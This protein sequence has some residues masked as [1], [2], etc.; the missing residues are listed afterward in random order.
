MVLS[1]P[2]IERVVQEKVRQQGRNNRT[3]RGPLLPRLQGAVFQRIVVA[4]GLLE[5]LLGKGAGIGN[6]QPAAAHVVQTADAVVVE[7]VDGQTIRARVASS[8]PSAD[9]ALLELESTPRGI[10]PAVLGDSA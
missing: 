5:V 4:A 6:N 7:F 1:H 2:P 8:V 3:L 10:G 9:V